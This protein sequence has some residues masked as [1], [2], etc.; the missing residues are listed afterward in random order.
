MVSTKAL[1]KFRRWAILLS[2][3]V[4]A[5]LTPTPDAINQ[6]LMAG[7]M[8]ILYEVGIWVSWFVDKSR[9]EEKARQMAQEQAD[10]TAAGADSGEAEAKTTAETPTDA[11][12]T[13]APDK[14]AG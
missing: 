3:V 2:F 14:D 9:K 12:D 8:W 11:G 13:T 5:V 4:S 7:P 10:E 1:R 6:L